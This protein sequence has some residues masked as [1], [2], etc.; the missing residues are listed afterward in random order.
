[1]SVISFPPASPTREPHRDATQADILRESTKQGALTYFEGVRMATD[2]A[3][4]CGVP[5]EERACWQF[6][7][8][9][10]TVGQLL[11]FFAKHGALPPSKQW[12]LWWYDGLPPRAYILIHDFR[13]AEAF[14]A[15]FEIPLP[16]R[17]MGVP[18]PYEAK[19]PNSSRCKE[20]IM[21]DALGISTDLI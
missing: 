5:G 15:H 17:T 12:D 13:L 8:G 18:S 6:P 20:D 9:D 19:G 7:M 3:F 14:A 16:Y 1:M 11:D 10:R 21:A 4:G 2:V